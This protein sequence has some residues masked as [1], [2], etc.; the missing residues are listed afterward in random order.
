MGRTLARSNYFKSV[1]QK[2]PLMTAEHMRKREAWCIAHQ[3]Y[4]FH[5]VIFTDES[6][7]QF[8]RCTRKR[9]AKFGHC[10]KMVPK[11]SPAVTVWGGI[12]KLGIT[13]LVSVNGNISAIK[14]CEILGEGLLLSNIVTNDF[15][16]CFTT[17]QR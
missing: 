7:F 16:V 14:Y 2:V 1:L 11:F 13:P 6:R 8:Y 5:N 12:S 17:G 9:W 10:Q 15:S 4:N 3:I